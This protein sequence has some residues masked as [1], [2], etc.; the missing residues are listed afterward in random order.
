MV[1]LQIRDVPDDVRR[2]LAERAQARGQS[3]QAFLLS[4]VQDEA[5]RSANLAQLDRFIGRDDGSRLSSDQ[6]TS[7]LDRA[8]AER[9]PEPTGPTS[10]GDIA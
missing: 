2:T 3:L 6:A 1:A 8:R 9:D 10:N 5:R 4:L 7:A